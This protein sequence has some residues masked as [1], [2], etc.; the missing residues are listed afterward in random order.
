MPTPADASNLYKNQIGVIAEDEYHTDGTLIY[1][2]TETQTYTYLDGN[3]ATQY[4]TRSAIV[5]TLTYNYTSADLTTLVGTN[6]SNSDTFTKTYT[7]TSGDVTAVSAW[8]KS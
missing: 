6:D 4:A 3:L 2:H 5:Y 7:W 1:P 8:V